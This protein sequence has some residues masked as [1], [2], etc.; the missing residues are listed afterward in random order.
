MTGPEPMEVSGARLT[1]W[2]AAP[3]LD[4]LRTGALGAFACDDAEAG[5]RLLRRAADTL[6]A[7][8]F[9]ALVGP[10]DGD[11]W[12]SHRLVVETDGRPPFLMEPSNPPHH[13]AA[14]D[15]AGFEVIA[16]YASAER[17]VDAARPTNPHPP[18]LIVRTLNMARVED[19][20]RRIHALSLETF[21]GNFLYRPIAAEGFLDLYRPIL[22]RLDPELVLLAEAAEGT[23]QAFLFG[24]PDLAQ[25]AVP[26]SVIMKTYASRVKGGGS[27]L[28]DCFAERTRDKGFTRVIH[29]LF[30]ENN[31]SAHRSQ[32]AGGRIFRRYALWGLR[33]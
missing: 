6:K 14:F 25:G 5:A 21:A 3:S 20:L 12:S 19:E 23:L 1:V 17:R 28:A 27:L 7:E 10:M 4:G 32:G 33:L 16:R 24:V 29:A 11:T 22:Q 2:R 18:A 9:Q 13:P 15:T 30:H 26:D 31:L 8:G